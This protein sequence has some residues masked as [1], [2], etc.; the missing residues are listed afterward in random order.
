MAVSGGTDARFWARRS[1][2]RGLAG[3]KSDVWPLNA[4]HAFGNRFTGDK[5][6]IGNGG[7]EQ[8]GKFVAQIAQERFADLIDALALAGNA[9]GGADDLRKRNEPLEGARALR[10][11]AGGAIGKFGHAMIDAY[12]QLFAADGAFSAQRNRFFRRKANAAAAMTV[13]MIF[14]FLGEEFQRAKKAIARVQSA[15]QGV[16]IFG[17]GEQI[18]FAAEFCGR[19][20]VGIGNEEIAIQRRNTPVHG[21]I[22]RKTRLQRVN[23]SGKVAKAIL[24]PVKAGKRAKEGKMRCPDMRGDADDARVGF[25]SQ[26]EQIVRGEAEDRAAVRTDIANGLQ[27][28]G[29]AIGGFK[30]GQQ[31]HGVHLARAPVLLVNGADFAAEHELRPGK[32]ARIG[33][34]QLRLQPVQAAAVVKQPFAQLLPPLRMGDIARAQQRN[35]LSAGPK[36]EMRRVAFAAG[37][38]GKTGMNVQIGDGHGLSSPKKNCGIIISLVGDLWRK[39]GDICPNGRFPVKKAIKRLDTCRE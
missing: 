33:N 24:K 34:S 7:A 27:P 1:T 10:A 36:G 29:K 3:T 13:K 25:Q 21:R 28:R 37:C 16:E 38:A 18:C 35:A 30:G 32:R 2:V 20:G 4:P 5:G 8:D 11:N 31:K 39:D 19:M 9:H 22:G 6:D 12:G 23:L 14:A 26:R 17:F 15:A